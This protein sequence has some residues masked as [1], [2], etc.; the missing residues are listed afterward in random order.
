[1]TQHEHFPDEHHDPYSKTIFG[2]WVYLLSDFLLFGAL[3]ASYMVLRTSTFG[4]PSG[5]DIF[6]LP[7][8]LSQ[9]IL[10]LTS[11]LTSGLAGA[12]AHRKNIAWTLILFTI[13]GIIGIFFIERQIEEFTKLVH[14]GYGWQKSAFLSM[15]FT[16]VGT[17]TLH[18]LF[19]ILWTIA[20]L[21]PV[22]LQG[23]NLISIRRLTCLRMFWQ[24][25]N[26]IWVFIFA[27]VYFMGGHVCD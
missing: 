10:L 15:F 2:F 7:A 23:I 27:I 12:M 18:M 26:I 1:M 11:S 16:L 6:N 14:A 21:I 20:L 4:G 8:A 19:A 5:H 25:L 3:F 24:F 22:C 13:T 9:A 17:H